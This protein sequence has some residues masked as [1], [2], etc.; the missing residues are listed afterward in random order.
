[1]YV[2]LLYHFVKILISLLIFCLLLT[3]TERTMLR[4]LP[5]IVGFVVS[6]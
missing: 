6:K 1:M 2:K 3:V 5:I 4:A